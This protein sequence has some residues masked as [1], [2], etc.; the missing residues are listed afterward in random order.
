MN[1]G[2]ALLESEVETAASPASAPTFL[3]EPEPWHKVFLSNLGSQFAD[4]RQPGLQLLS[5]HGKF[6]PDVFVPSPLPWARF[7]ESMCYHA[8]FITAIVMLYQYLPR[9]TAIVGRRVFTKEDA[10]YFKSEYLPPLDTGGPKVHLPR[11]AEPQLAK[12]PIISVPPDA[13]NRTQTIVAPP[14][15]KLKDE[16]PLPNVVAAMP[17]QATVVLDSTA[18]SMTDRRMPSLPTTVVAPAPELN[19]PDSRHQVRA[20][21]AAVVEPTPDMKTVSTRRLADVNIAHSDAVAPAPQLAMSERRAVSSVPL[22]NSG[23]RVVPPAPSMQGNANSNSGGRMIALGI[24]PV[25]PGRPVQAPTGNRRGTF[26][27]TPDGKAGAPGTPGSSAGK[28]QT[29]AGSANGAKG[30][31]PGLVVGAVPRS[32][33]AASGNSRLI[34]N[35]TPPRVRSFPGESNSQT[36]PNATELEKQVFGDKK[37]YS[38]TLNLPNLNSRGGSWVVHFAQLVKNDLKGDLTAPVAV[39]EVDP[40]YPTELMRRNVQGTVTL[41]AVIH[42]DGSVGE[43]RVLRGVDERLDQYACAALAGWHFRPATKNGYPIDLEAVVVIPFHPIRVK[44]NF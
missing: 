30:I 3:I 6:W 13:D 22:G 12:Q 16:V 2:L 35:A 39:K 14:Q 17:V 28:N 31:P 4:R 42:N 15:I 29:A 19:A 21:Q 32:S 5:A 7:L 8:V 20:P 37:F 38:M 25:E 26:A 41:Y 10:L 36:N 9:P 43:V 11:K 27:A 1:Q 18:R 40:G 34:A 23:A 44:S 24:H 33:D